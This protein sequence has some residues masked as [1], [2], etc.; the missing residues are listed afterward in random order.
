MT[1]L[2]RQR[3]GSPASQFFSFISVLQGLTIYRKHD[4]KATH[5]AVANP[6]FPYRSWPQATRPTRCVQAL[7][8]RGS[9]Y[10]G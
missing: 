2:R 5:P 10:F 7:G 1:P 8:Q 3:H 9:A 4:R 6:V